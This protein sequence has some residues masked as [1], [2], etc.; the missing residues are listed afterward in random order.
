[1]EN[2]WHE[3]DTPWGKHLVL[4]LEFGPRDA[5]LAW[6]GEA[7][8]AHPDHR[9][10]V[11][12]HAHLFNDSKRYDWAKYGKAQTW[13]PKEYAL[14][15]DAA[16]SGGVNDGEDVWRSCSRLTKTYGSCSTAMCSGLAP[17]TASTRDPTRTAGSSNAR[18]LSGGGRPGAHSTAAGF[19]DSFSFCPTG[20][21]CGS[22]P[23]RPGS[24]SG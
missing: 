17:G 21:L 7:A 1:M 11:T 16:A 18:Q 4:A 5:V 6:A 15:R 19:S 3:F 2:S 13:N 24:I 8:A 9:V 10:I 22:E 23:I 20:N 12:S 14:A